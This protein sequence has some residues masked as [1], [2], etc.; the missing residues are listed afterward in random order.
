MRTSTGRDRNL[1]HVRPE[2]Q[3]EGGW[4][5]GRRKEEREGEAVK[6]GWEVEEHLPCIHEQGGSIVPLMT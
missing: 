1:V 6:E 2:V 3:A 5:V 4:R